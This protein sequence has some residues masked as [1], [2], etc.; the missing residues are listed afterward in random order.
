[1]SAV[2]NIIGAVIV[3][4]I[5]VI[6]TL[7]YLGNLS[8]ETIDKYRDSRQVFLEDK[9]TNDFTSVFSVNEP[10]TSRQIGILVADAVYYRTP[11]LTVN[12]Q[13]LNVTF[14]LQRILDSVYGQGGYYVIAKPRIIEVHM[15]FVIDGSRTLQEER[16]TLSKNLPALINNIEKK[17]RKIGNE[18]VIA[19]IFSLEKDYCSGQNALF[20][21]SDPR[22][23]CKVLSNQSLYLSSLP[24]NSTSNYSSS[25]DTLDYFKV[26][27]NLTPPMG[28]GFKG[29]ISKQTQ[30]DWG[31]GSAYATFYNEKVELSKLVMIFPMSDQLSSGSVSGKC[32]E[33]SDYCEYSVCSLCEQECS[34]ETGPVLGPSRQ[35]RVSFCVWAG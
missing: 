32:F 19:T 25:I 34:G 5:V 1:M 24:S 33:R 4:M 18:K 16:L 6:G 11:V 3:L 29:D 17:I 22:I 21:L 28:I 20:N 10:K 2:E 12:N 35:E 30:S 23:E 15:N 27:Y 9:Y 7:V 26:Y 14:E 13:S 31:T 8:I